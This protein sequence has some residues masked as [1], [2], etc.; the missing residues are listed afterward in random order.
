MDDGS[1]STIDLTIE[2]KIKIQKT[3]W[4]LFEKCLTS[5]EYFLVIARLWV[6]K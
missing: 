4:S 2:I 5:F 6:T 1:I 3:F